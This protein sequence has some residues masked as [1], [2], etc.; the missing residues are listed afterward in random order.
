MGELV[1]RRRQD[2][3]CIVK[4]W[5]GFRGKNIS[6]TLWINEFQILKNTKKPQ[7]FICGFLIFR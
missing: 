5:R 4:H 3:S 6:K 2:A 7:T 1:A